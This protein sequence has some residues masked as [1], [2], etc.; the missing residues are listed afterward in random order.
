MTIDKKGT[1]VN[2]HQSYNDVVILFGVRDRT[3]GTM[4]CIYASTLYGRWDVVT[5]GKEV[6]TEMHGH[7]ARS[8]P[9]GLSLRLGSVMNILL[10]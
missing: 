1:S 7:L 5:R 9:A 4:P 10:P 3:V 2:H 6:E 8:H